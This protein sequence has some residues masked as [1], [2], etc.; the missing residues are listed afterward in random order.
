MYTKESFKLHKTGYQKICHCL[1]N[2]DEV[3]SSTS[4]LAYN[5]CIKG[6][7]KET[8]YAQESY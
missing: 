2:W 5:M 1:N 6:L 8:S 3:S 4:W 7:E